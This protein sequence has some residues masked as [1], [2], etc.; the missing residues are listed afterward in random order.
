MV[1]QGVTPMGKTACLE[2]SYLESQLKSIYQLWIM[3]SRLT[4]PEIIAY[5]FP[6]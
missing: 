6:A 1:V 2:K 4:M 3:V 5:N